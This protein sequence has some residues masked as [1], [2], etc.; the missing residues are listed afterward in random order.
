VDAIESVKCSKLPQVLI[1]LLNRFRRG[2]AK[3]ARKVTTHV[4]FPQDLDMT[5]FSEG[6][7]GEKKYVLYGVIVHKGNRPTMGHYY[8]WLRLGQPKRWIRFS[9]VHVQRGAW[10]TV[11]QEGSLRVDVF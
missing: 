1:L 6:V 5:P 10:D 9:D 11:K 8:C 2:D 7:A 4:S 3:S